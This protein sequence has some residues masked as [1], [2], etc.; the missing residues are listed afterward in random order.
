MSNLKEHQSFFKKIN[1]IPPNQ[2]QGNPSPFP[3]CNGKAIHCPLSIVLAT[4]HTF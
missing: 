4:S 3:I 1:L 2:F